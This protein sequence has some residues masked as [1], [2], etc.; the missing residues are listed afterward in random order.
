MAKANV[1][2][3]QRLR[4]GIVGGIDDGKGGR[5]WLWAC[6]VPAA[7]SG[8]RRPRGGGAGRR[9]C[10]GVVGWRCCGDIVTAA[11]GGGGRAMARGEVT[12]NTLLGGGACGKARG[13]GLRQRWTLSCGS[14]EGGGGGSNVVAL[15]ATRAED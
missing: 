13:S 1:G 8:T 7:L 5:R 4:G 3:S 2:A 6:R 12:I 14:G 15:A 9:A 11:G 10:R